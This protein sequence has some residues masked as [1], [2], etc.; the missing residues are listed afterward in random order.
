MKRSPFQSKACL[1]TPPPP[2]IHL[3]FF[4]SP[5]P[6]SLTLILGA[7]CH[8]NELLICFPKEFL[9]PRRPDS[10]NTTLV[11]WSTNNFPGLHCLSKALFHAGADHVKNVLVQ[12]WPAFIPAQR[13]QM[14]RVRISKHVN[15]HERKL[16]PLSSTLLQSSLSVS[17]ISSDTSVALT[18]AR[19][20]FHQVD[21]R[22]LSQGLT[23]THGRLLK[24]DTC[25]VT[26]ALRDT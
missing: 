9:V 21:S 5:L 26:A 11:M 1:P 3:S 13:C 2:F 18:Q 23:A 8:E 4:L 14:G 19:V 22:D 15:P 17:G 20:C 6:F 25:G 24:C 12:G 16:G 7:N 10:R